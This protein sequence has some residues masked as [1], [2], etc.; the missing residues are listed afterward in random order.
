[1]LRAFIILLF[2]GFNHI[3]S[4]QNNE[5]KMVLI[6]TEF[7]TM[8]VKL[9]NNTPKHGG[10]FY[11]LAS[12][13][14]YDSTLFHRV[15]GGF[16]IQGGDPESR[17]ALPGKM[18]GGGD[19]NYR[20][21]AEINDSLFHK[22]GALAAARDNNPDKSSSGCQF[23][24]VQGT[25]YTDSTL[26]LMER[27]INAEAKQKIFMSLINKEENKKLKEKMI[28]YQQSGK[29]D[30]LRLLT[31]QIEPIIESEFSKS[32]PFKFSPEKRNAYKTVGGAAHLD[33]NYTVFGEVT[34]GLDV[35]DKLASVPKDQADRPLTDIRMKVSVIK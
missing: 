21:T 16:M 33:G 27:R 34:E 4:A 6:S 19:V 28:A 3:V 5:F 31:S 7:G 10:N 12:E 15:I 2:I 13:G 26:N 1:M 30:S 22:K 9:Y 24:I 17:H 20:I 25:V 8:K 32:K 35:I 23:Y 18:L 14:F 11:K 29:M